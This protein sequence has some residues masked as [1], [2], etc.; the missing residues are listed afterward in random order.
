[1]GFYSTD[2]IEHLFLA[3]RINDTTHIYNAVVNAFKNGGFQMIEKANTWNVMW[4]G[5][6]KFEDI[7]EM[8]KYQKVNHFPGSIQ[9]GRKDLL[10]KNIYRVRQKFGK[11]LDI[12]PTTYLFPMDY[13]QFLLDREAEDDNVLY[14]LKPVASSCG[15][16]IKVVGKK[17]KISKQDGYLASKYLA[18]PHLINGFKYDLRVYVLVSSFDPLRIYVYNDGLVRFATEKYSL[19]PSDLKKKFIHLTNF[20]VNKKSEN[21]KDNKGTGEGEESSSKWS[22]KALKKAY[23]ANGINFD[24]VFA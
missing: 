15:R 14:I 6:T 4:T 13:N 5:Y 10:W 8:N 23:E 19:N 7:R 1:M 24:F 18:Y 9:L 17:S 2:E 21:F 22:F 20:S 12:A 3:F 16:G 11:E